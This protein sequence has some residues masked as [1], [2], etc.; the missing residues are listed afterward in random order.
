MSLVRFPPCWSRG[1]NGGS[2]EVI[3]GYSLESQPGVMM[4]KHKG[5]DRREAV[6]A[7]EQDYGGGSELDARGDWRAVCPPLDDFA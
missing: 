6:L 3:S 5:V 2:D 4:D 7:V 1:F